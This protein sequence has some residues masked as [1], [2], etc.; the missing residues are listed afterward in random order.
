MPDQ[1]YL[2]VEIR[3]MTGIGNSFGYFQ[4]N[5]KSYAGVCKRCNNY[6]V[7]NKYSNERKEG[8]SMVNYELLLRDVRDVFKDTMKKIIFDLEQEKI[9]EIK[10]L[11]LDPDVTKKLI[12]MQKDRTFLEMLLTNSLM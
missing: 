7:I 1:G 9:K 3:S 10:D 4:K 8:I 12:L 5:D 11:N 6:R 2:A